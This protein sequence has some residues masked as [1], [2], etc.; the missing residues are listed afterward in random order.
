MMDHILSERVTTGEESN[1]ATRFNERYL[2]FMTRHIPILGNS[3]LGRKPGIHHLEYGKHQHS[4]WMQG[5]TFQMLLSRKDG[6]R[7]WAVIN[8]SLHYA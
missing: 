3:A 1:C 2:A 8:A 7:F 5:V 6:M 4:P